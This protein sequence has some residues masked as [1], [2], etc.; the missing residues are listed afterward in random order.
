MAV[1]AST[2][3][4][5]KWRRTPQE[6]GCLS[7]TRTGTKRWQ[8]KFARRISALTSQWVST[9]A[10][11]TGQR[12]RK[13][14]LGRCSQTRTVTMITV[15]HTTSAS[16]TSTRLRRTNRFA[17]GSENIWLQWTVQ[18]RPLWKVSCSNCI[19]SGGWEGFLGHYQDQQSSNGWHI[20]H[21]VT[22][23]PIFKTD[24]RGKGFYFLNL[25]AQVTQVS[26]DSF[27]L[28]FFFLEGLLCRK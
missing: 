11:W 24:H 15:T 5:F 27:F 2:T 18:V 10:C 3:A 9:G 19:V 12:F 14:Q 26:G 28:F 16:V 8:E 6:S 25:L 1:K 17:S 7:V 13:I 21:R 23:S 4:S 20:D 22:Y